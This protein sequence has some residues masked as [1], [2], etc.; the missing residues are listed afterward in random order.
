MQAN[1][2]YSLLFS[3][4]SKDIPIQLHYEVIKKMHSNSFNLTKDRFCLSFIAAFNNS[5][6]NRVGETEQCTLNQTVEFDLLR[7]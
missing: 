4:R 5:L 6:W 3:I 7:T 1:F 2:H